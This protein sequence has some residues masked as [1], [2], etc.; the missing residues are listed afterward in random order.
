MI[1]ITDSARAQLARMLVGAPEDMAV[2][3]VEG[4]GEGTWQLATRLDRVRPDDETVTHKGR[5]VLVADGEASKSVDA[6]TLDV[7]ETEGRLEFRFR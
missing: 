6:L 1:T 2:R 5:T 4:P 3:I 7:E